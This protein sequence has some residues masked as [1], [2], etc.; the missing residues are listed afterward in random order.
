MSFQS[1]SFRPRV[2]I[3]AFRW[4][5]PRRR[6]LNLT[7]VLVA[8]FI[9][10]TGVVFVA[11]MIP[12]GMHQLGSAIR[13]DRAS[14][15][16]HQGWAEAEVR[17]VLQF[18]DENGVAMLQTAGGAPVCPTVVKVT[19][20]TPST[21]NCGLN[22]IGGSKVERIA[23]RYNQ[24]GTG[25]FAIDPWGISFNSTLECFPYR[26]GSGASAVSNGDAI[27]RLTIRNRVRS[28]NSWNYRSTS[29]GSA[30]DCFVARRMF[31]STDDPAFSQDRISQLLRP[32]RVTA[33]Y[34]TSVVER[35]RPGEFGGE[36]TWMYTVSP[37]MSGVGSAFSGTSYSNAQLVDR[38]I[39]TDMWDYHVSTAVFFRRPTPSTV[40]PAVSEAD[41]FFGNIRFSNPAGASG[42]DSALGGGEALL[43][44]TN[45]TADSSPGSYPKPSVGDWIMVYKKIDEKRFDRDRCFEQA[46]DKAQL[47]RPTVARWYRIRAVD[48]VVD[49]SASTMALRVLLDGPD[50]D[51]SLFDIN[52]T[53][54]FQANFA[55]CKR[56]VSVVERTVR[57]EY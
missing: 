16:A 49:P 4:T 48:P 11:A 15:A 19:G 18:V 7:E 29:A 27:P 41:E 22:G 5:S 45:V 51:Y 2:R 9:A 1:A 32:E 33:S 57:L 40:G 42:A 28:G 47:S 52:S 35:D 12:I 6:G 44:L 13:S 24:G 8:T 25:A 10:V 14:T 26:T 17:Q 31:T 54:G 46:S 56:V 23:D 39:G 3:R 36:Y 38:P 37:I 55:Y 43:D 30:P 53:N 50:W 21:I 34:P 20:Q